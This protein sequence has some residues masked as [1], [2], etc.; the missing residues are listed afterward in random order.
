MKI[1]LPFFSD[2]QGI[3]IVE[4]VVT[5]SIGILVF[6]GAVV[7]FK[8]WEMFERGRDNKRLSDISTLERMISEYK[9][10]TEEYPGVDNVTY[11]STSLPSGSAG[12][13]FDSVNGWIGP[14]FNFSS[15]SLKLPIDPTNTGDLRYTYMKSGE[16]FEINAVLEYNTEL[17][18][19]DGGDDNSFYEVGNDLTLL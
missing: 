3:T 8:P 1:N 7:I 12:P 18:V 11:Y 17:M 14:G 5:F 4:L 19:D 9:I 13:L 10:D 6:S 15:Y 2:Q 16:T